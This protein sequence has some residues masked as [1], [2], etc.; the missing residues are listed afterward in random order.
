MLVWRDG[1]FQPCD[2]H[3]TAP[4]VDPYKYFMSRHL[5]W[6]GNVVPICRHFWDSGSMYGHD[7]SSKSLQYSSG[8]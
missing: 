3:A 1:R 5:V 8:P 6:C 4:V 7:G 2:A